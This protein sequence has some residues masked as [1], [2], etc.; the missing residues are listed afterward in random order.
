MLLSAGAVALAANRLAAD[1]RGPVASATPAPADDISAYLAPV[2]A[3]LESSRPVV[4]LHSDPFDGGQTYV[5][6]AIPVASGSDAPTVSA[7]ARPGRQL[8]A[9]LIADDRPVAVIDGAVYNLGDV[10]PDGARVATIRADRVSLLEANGQWRV[11][12]IHSGRR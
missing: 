4:Q 11:L 7:S 9:I 1:P 10:L 5:P 12:I 3:R 6:D 8:T 2:M